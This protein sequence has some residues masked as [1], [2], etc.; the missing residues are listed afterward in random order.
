MK[1]DLQ[2][3]CAVCPNGCRLS[4]EIGEDRVPRPAET[5]RCV[6]GTLMIGKEYVL[7]GE[8][9]IELEQP[10]SKGQVAELVEQKKK[11]RTLSNPV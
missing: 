1:Q 2:F 11:D 3:T 5:G 7:T 9:L 6:R 4:V 10:L 8:T